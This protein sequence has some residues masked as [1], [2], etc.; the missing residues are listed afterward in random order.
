MGNI[1]KHF[2]REEFAC[3]CCKCESI[4]VDHELI[5]VLEKLRNHTGQPITITSAYRCQKHNKSVGGATKSKHR[6]GIAADIQVKNFSPADIASYFRNQYPTK[7]GVGEY[8]SFVHI[9]VR[10]DAARWKG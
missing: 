9:D 2:D 4:A 7:Y 5:E 6:L 10:Q 8:S 1:S 3:K